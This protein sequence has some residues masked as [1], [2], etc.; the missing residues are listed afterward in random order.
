MSDLN[1]KPEACALAAG[2]KQIS[3]PALDDAAAAGSAARGGTSG[4]GV[5]RRFNATR[6]AQPIDD[7]F[8]PFRVY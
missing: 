8:R 2:D 6:L 1:F 5:R 3:V 4:R 7:G